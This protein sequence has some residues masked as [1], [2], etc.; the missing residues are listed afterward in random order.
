MSDIEGFDSLTDTLTDKVTKERQEAAQATAKLKQ[1]VSG[2][3]DVL[4]GINDKFSQS[5]DQIN[6]KQSAVTQSMIDAIEQKRRMESLPGIVTKIGSMFDESFDPN[7]HKANIQKGQVKLNDLQRTRES[8]TASRRHSLETLRLNTQAAATEADTENQEAQLARQELQDHLNL[9]GM[10]NQAAS[11]VFNRYSQEQ[12]VQFKDNPNK[13]PSEVRELMTSHEGIMESLILA[14]KAKVTSLR[15]AQLSNQAQAAAIKANQLGQ[16]LARMSDDEIAT[17]ITNPESVQQLFPDEK[18]AAIKALLEDQQLKNQ[19]FSLAVEHLN[20]Q[21]EAGDAAQEARAK[22]LVMRSMTTGMLQAAAQEARKTG[23]VKIGNVQFG[24]QE[25]R[26]AAATSK[27]KDKVTINLVQAEIAKQANSQTEAMAAFAKAKRVSSLVGDATSV[28]GDD[29]GGLTPELR[30]QIETNMQLIAA[31]R[32]AGATDQMEA[33]AKELTEL[34]NKQAEQAL[35]AIEDEDAKDAAEFY[36]Q[37]GKLTQRHAAQWAAA[38]NPDTH[39]SSPILARVATEI[40]SAWRDRVD[41]A[42]TGFEQVG[43]GETGKFISKN[44]ADGSKTGITVTTQKFKAPDPVQFMT[45]TIKNKQLRTAVGNELIQI[46]ITRAANNLAAADKIGKRHGPTLEKASQDVFANITQDGGLNP[47]LF[48]AEGNVDQ[49]LLFKT[50]VE[51]T[52]QDK[53]EGFTYQGALISE[54]RQVMPNLIET[55]LSPA[56]IHDAALLKLVVD[57]QPQTMMD[58]AMRQLSTAVTRMTTAVNERDNR[59]AQQTGLNNSPAGQFV[60]PIERAAVSELIE[61]QQIVSETISSAS[62]TVTKAAEDVFGMIKGI[63]GNSS[64][65]TDQ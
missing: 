41:R 42:T 47:A 36:L 46:A 23:N 31:A 1:T 39:T 21:V 52:S 34:V 8:V 37:N 59:Q 50:L 63:L 13:A 58:T 35:A 29:L 32:K 10:Q 38:F 57:N 12:L 15:S 28:I 9:P 25:L 3:P 45:D 43:A 11:N 27:G 64:E 56:N 65:Q 24:F 7:T 44:R 55:H 2:V 22:T 33:R 19:Q 60:G 18:P 61:Q 17:G 4:K 6:R 5:I 20:N 48:D 51:A 49:A 40:S 54:M 62:E 26:D 14:K 53:P 16:T 30:K